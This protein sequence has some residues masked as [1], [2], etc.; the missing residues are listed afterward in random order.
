MI[1]KF[2]I[3]AS[4]Q[5]VH[6]LTLQDGPLTARVITYGCALQDVRLDGLQHSLTVGSPDISAYEGPL[7][8]CGT[9]M[10]PVANRIAG[11]CAAIDGIEYRFEKNFL[12]VLPWHHPD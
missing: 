11:A 2:G 4:G 7:G 12:A 8:H 5:E 6:R 1:E 10:G 3:T 9:I